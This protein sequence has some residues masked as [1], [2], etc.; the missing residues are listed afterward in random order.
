MITLLYTIIKAI[1]LES[2]KRWYWWQIS[3]FCGIFGLICSC[4]ILLKKQ[5]QIVHMF[6]HYI[7]G[8]V[9]LISV[10]VEILAVIGCYGSKRI[11]SDFEFILGR[12]LPI[13][14][15]I[16][17]WLCPFILCG[18]FLWAVAEIVHITGYLTE[19]PVWL[20][21]TG[22]AIVLLA[23]V[24]ILAM[25]FFQASK[26]D[27][28]YTFNDKLK[29]ALKFSRKWGPV[30]PIMRYNWVQWHSKAKNGQRDFTLRRRG[31]REYTHSVKNRS[32]YSPRKYVPAS[33]ESSVN[34]DSIAFRKNDQNQNNIAIMSMSTY[35]E[36][37]F[38]I[39]NIHNKHLPAT[40]IPRPLRVTS[41]VDT[42][43]PPRNDSNRKS[44]PYYGGDDYKISINPLANLNKP[45][46]DPN[47]DGGTSE[48][49]GTFRNGP[50][51]IEGEDVDHV[52]HRKVSTYSE[53]AT[54]L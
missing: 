18:I 51:V 16:L 39:N 4:L 25:G 36:P 37:Y 7:V 48:G 6:D 3:I 33:N 29:A 34:T 9:I 46:P 23:I 41:L 19:D 1:R 50:Y 52:C 11:Q 47:G 15:I 5:F 49:Y 26:Q 53:E 12:R 17:W 43:D 24:F 54:E 35:N 27:D 14:Y 30:D 10:I 22:W 2:R 31:T 44:F 21:A 20:Y 28:Y 38:P 13:I 8:N 42:L 45:K 40:T 32:K